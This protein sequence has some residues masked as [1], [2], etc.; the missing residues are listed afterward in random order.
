MEMCLGIK[1]ATKSTGILLWE[2]S[3][4]YNRMQPYLVDGF[5]SSEKYESQLGWFFPTYGKIK[6]FQTTKQIA[7]RIELG[8][9]YQQQSMGMVH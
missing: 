9:N 5:N 6:L 1:K 4:T 2:T 7:Y 3:L 8:C